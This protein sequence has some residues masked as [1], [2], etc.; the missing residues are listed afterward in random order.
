MN[1]QQRF[2]HRKFVCTR[3]SHNGAIEFATMSSTAQQRAQPSQ[4]RKHK[5][6]NMKNYLQNFQIFFSENQF[7]KIDI[8]RQR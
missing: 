6:K 8:S 5:K 4:S 2:L 7:E 1:P 3:Y